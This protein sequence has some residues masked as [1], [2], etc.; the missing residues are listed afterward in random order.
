[1]VAFLEVGG[2]PAASAAAAGCG[3]GC[4]G[5]GSGVGGGGGSGGLLII[6]ERLSGGA[7]V[8]LVLKYGPMGLDGAPGGRF[9]GRPLAA[10]VSVE[11]LAGLALLCDGCQVAGQS[12]LCAHL[13][14]ALQPIHNLLRE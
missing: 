1:M 14:M 6:L 8:C 4:G 12:T 10:H 2:G 11:G 7:L 3:R 9:A 13:G 5:G